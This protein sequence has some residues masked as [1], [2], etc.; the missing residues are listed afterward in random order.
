MTNAQIADD[1]GTSVNRSD[2][3]IHRNIVNRVVTFSNRLI[4]FKAA[5][6][7]V[8]PSAKSNNSN[9]T[10]VGYVGKSAEVG[11]GPSSVRGST[12]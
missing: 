4:A 7:E 3:S 9:E 2:E 1:F 12:S 5:R 10:S 6:S 11:V 8:A